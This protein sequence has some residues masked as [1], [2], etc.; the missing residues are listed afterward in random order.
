MVTAQI[1]ADFL[2]KER[3]IGTTGHALL[4]SFFLPLGIRE[5]TKAIDHPGSM[6]FEGNSTHVMETSEELSSDKETCLGK[7]KLPLCTRLLWSS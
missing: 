7:F 6:S 4:T 2:E 5:A 1:M 3:V